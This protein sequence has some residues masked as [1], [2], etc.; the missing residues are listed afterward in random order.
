MNFLLRLIFVVSLIYAVS[1]TRPGVP[2]WIEKSI[3]AA[4]ATDLSKQAI[5]QAQSAVE[6]TITL[7]AKS[8]D[9][10]INAARSTGTAHANQGNSKS[11]LDGLSED[12]STTDL[13]AVALPIEPESTGS[14]ASNVP[15]P[16]R[17]L[18]DVSS[19]KKI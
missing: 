7:C 4:R 12:S 9:A 10:C 5:D 16:P 2:Y 3:L 17:R 8:T 19:E 11:L 1:P 13:M 15:L 14:I 6:N 18:P